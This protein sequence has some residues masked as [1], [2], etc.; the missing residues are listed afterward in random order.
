MFG[1]L[2]LISALLSV[3]IMMGAIKGLSGVRKM[4]ML[5]G[6]V[7][8]ELYSETKSNKIYLLEHIVKT[9]AYSN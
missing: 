8:S 2:H 6:E 9:C 1:S 5:L 3:I 7:L 4:A